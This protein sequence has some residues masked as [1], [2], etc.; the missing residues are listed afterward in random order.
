MLVYFTHFQPICVYFVLIAYS[1]V[2]RAQSYSFLYI[3]VFSKAYREEV[4]LKVCL[5]LIV[6]CNQHTTVTMFHLWHFRNNSGLS[7][8]NH[9]NILTAL[10]IQFVSMLSHY[11]LLS[12]VALCGDWSITILSIMYLLITIKCLHY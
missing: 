10:W 2:T 11:H 8:C 4:L 6:L 3:F 9:P 12:Y 5:L 7:K 1:K